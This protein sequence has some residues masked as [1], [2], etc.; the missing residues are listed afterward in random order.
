MVRLLSAPATNAVVVATPDAASVRSAYLT[1][2][3]LLSSGIAAP[4]LLINKVRP[5]RIRRGE[6]A[7][8]DELIDRTELRLIGVVPLCDAI[9]DSAVQGRLSFPPDCAAAEAFRR[10]ARRMQGESVPLTPM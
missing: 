10:I 8:L 1:G 6:Q 7:N 4:R 3:R 9:A 2:E 5:E